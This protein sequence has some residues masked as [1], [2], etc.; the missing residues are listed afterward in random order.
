M[1]KWK[2]DRAA[3][4][5]QQDEDERKFWIDRRRDELDKSGRRELDAAVQSGEILDELAAEIRSQKLDEAQRKIDG[6][7]AGALGG[8]AADTPPEGAE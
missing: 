8:P 5:E 7:E 3:Q 2:L 6:A 4:L 1:E